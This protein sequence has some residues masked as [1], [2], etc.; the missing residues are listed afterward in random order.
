MTT[1]LNLLL[2]LPPQLGLLE[3]FG[4]GLIA[5]ANYVSSHVRGA[6]VC[7]LDLSLTPRAYLAARIRDAAERLSEP[8]VVGITTTTASYQSALRVAKLFRCCRPEATIALGGHHAS[9]EAEVVLQRHPEVDC[10]ICGEGEIA[11]AEL[12]ERYPHFA[13]VPNLAYW[14][15]DQIVRNPIARLLT[16]D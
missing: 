15:G 6:N 12:L 14:E 1:P 9:P 11:M 16:P 3:G 13:D 2:V 5:L 8:L 7:I 10:V 4:G